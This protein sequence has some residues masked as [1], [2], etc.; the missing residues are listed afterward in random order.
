MIKFG[1]KRGAIDAARREIRAYSKRVENAILMRLEFVLEELKN[2]AKTHAGY[3]FHTGNLNSSIGGG[4]YKNGALV[5]W[6]GFEVEQGGDDGA[7]IGIEYLNNVILKGRSTYSVVI[8]VGMEYVSFVENYYNKNVLA[9]TEMI[10][11]EA[12]EWA[13]RTMK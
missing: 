6:R 11:G 4:V 12:V 5:S 7:R 13:F 1:M 9:Q 2:H 3:N 8:V 10:A